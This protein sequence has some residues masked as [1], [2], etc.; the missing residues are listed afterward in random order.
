MDLK[1]N[2]G[3]GLADAII[4][5]GIFIIFTGIIVSI[6]YNIYLQSNFLKR[7]EQATNFIVDAFEY[8]QGLIFEN[9]NAEAIV[10]YINNKYNNVK[11]INQEYVE[12]AEKQAAYTIF[13]NVTD[14]KP[15]FIK[16]IDVTVMYKLGAK[17]KIV[18]MSTLVNK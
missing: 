2:K 11:A 4:A 14:E 18:N 10:S 13:I 6:S 3:I 15:N 5:I 1:Q 16:K 17:N 12:G 8:T 7:N 9:I